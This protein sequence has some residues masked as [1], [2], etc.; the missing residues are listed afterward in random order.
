MQNEDFSEK[1]RSISKNKLI[2]I[3]NLFGRKICKI[4]KKN[5]IGYFCKYP[6]PDQFHPITVLISNALNK[7]DIQIYMEILLSINNGK[8][9]IKLFL[10]D[11]RKVYNSEFLDVAIIEIYQ[12]EKDIFG[13]CVNINDY[14]QYF[15]LDNNFD[16]EIY[17]EK[18]IYLLQ[19]QFNQNLSLSEG[20]IKRIFDKVF[21]H[22]CNTRNVLYGGPIISKFNNKVIGNQ[23]KKN[24][25]A[26]IIK[27]AFEEFKKKFLK[28]EGINNDNQYN[29]NQ[30]NFM[31]NQ[32]NNNNQKN[33]MNNQYNN[34]N[35]QNNIMYNQ[36]NNNNQKIYMNNQNNDNN[37]QNNYM[38][39]QNNNMNTQ[40]NNMNNQNIII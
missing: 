25:E 28:I 21:Q 36:N 39:N 15:E 11:K 16:K 32:N 26:T 22:N 37:N 34:N 1:D 35:S 9:E 2:Q 19:Y 23:R 3:N 6:F 31:F 27:V 10:D 30:N 29:N 38:N 20:I 7:E 18:A 4:N 40:N 5:I 17:E 8:N 24:N 33:F 12:K 13:N 14:I